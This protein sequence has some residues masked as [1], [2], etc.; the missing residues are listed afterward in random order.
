MV[1][2]VGSV[3][4]V[5]ARGCGGKLSQQDAVLSKEHDAAQSKRKAHMRICA[6]ARTSGVNVTTNDD[7]DDDALVCN[8]WGDKQRGVEK[9][10]QATMYALMLSTFHNGW[11]MVVIRLIIKSLHRASQYT[12]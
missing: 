11:N 4:S 1:L 3:V 7:V 6:Y 10:N 12:H 2:C 5:F 8:S 9:F